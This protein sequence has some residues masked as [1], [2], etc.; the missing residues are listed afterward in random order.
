[1]VHPQI[2]SPATGHST[3]PNKASHF[4]QLPLAP[5]VQVIETTPTEP[6]PRSGSAQIPKPRSARIKFSAE[7]DLIIIK[8]VAATHAHL[9]SFGTVQR[10]FADAAQKTNSNPNF[11]GCVNAR[12]I[13]ERFRKIMSTFKKEEARDRARSGTGGELS[14]ADGLLLDMME[15]VESVK[16]VDETK[17]EEEANANK[18]KLEAGREILEGAGG[19]STITINEQNGTGGSAAVVIEDDDDDELRTPKGP[20]RRRGAQQ[21]DRGSGLRSFGDALRDG[22]IARVELEAKRLAFDE[23]KH[24]DLL[25][26]REKDREEEAKDRERNSERDMERFKMMLEFATKTIASTVANAQEEKK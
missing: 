26:E 7:D 12:S 3:Q 18:R 13:Q 9:A 8:E 25:R 23:K 5:P 4:S 22:E 2:D 15:A 1:M 10:K 16:E 20:K 11:R 6:S 21:L 24:D 14:E 17:K 19:T